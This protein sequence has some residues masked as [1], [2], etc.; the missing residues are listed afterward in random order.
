M[1]IAV[2][3]SGNGGHIF[4]ADLS[5]AGHTVFWCKLGDYTNASWNKVKR[6]HMLRLKG[7]TMAAT[8]NGKVKI[9]MMTNSIK[10]AVENA[11]H[12]FVATTAN[13]HLE[14]IQALLQCKLKGKTI[15]FF[16]GR[17][18]CLLFKRQL[19]LRG[20]KQ[21]FVLAESSCFP[22]VTRISKPGVIHSIGFKNK[23][24]LAAFPANA[25]Q[26]VIDSIK[27]VTPIVMPVKNVLVTSLIDHCC[28][29]HPLAILKNASKI[30]SS[31]GQK[32]I[33]FYGYNSDIGALADAADREKLQ[34]LQ[35]LNA[36]ILSI[37]DILALFYDAK[38]TSTYDC[39]TTVSYYGQFSLPNNINNR[40]LTEDIPFSLVPMYHLA[41]KFGINPNYISMIISEAGALLDIDFM[42]KGYSLSE[43][44]IDGL[45]L[46]QL[47]RYLQNGDIEQSNINKLSTTTHTG[48]FK[49]RQIL[50]TEAANNQ[51]RLEFIMSKL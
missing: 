6:D 45:S 48:F 18:A 12:I 25:T 16:P 46:Q 51:P 38:G 4:A 27:T 3:G 28:I 23:L 31:A 21:N 26:S 29:M 19:D 34:L 41:C 22:Y 20:L 13:R 10:Q 40:Y 1:K 44:G 11:S 2:L 49:M 36:D 50:P 24:P 9:H 17:H 47:Q 35:Q 14:Y 42:T 5:L 43:L 7:K 37:P 8:N 15:I 39:I 33:P 32:I 30:Q